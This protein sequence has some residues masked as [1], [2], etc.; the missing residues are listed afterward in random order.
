MLILTRRIGERIIFIMPDGRQVSVT[1]LSYHGKQIRIGCIADD[2]INIVREELLPSKARIR[3]EY[4]DEGY[5]P[6]DNA[7]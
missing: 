5:D 6:P 1:P 4:L 2:D 3:R 7:A